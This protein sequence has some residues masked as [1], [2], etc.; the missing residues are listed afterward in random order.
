[1]RLKRLEALT[2]GGVDE[3]RPSVYGSSMIVLIISTVSG[4]I[5]FVA[6]VTLKTA[7]WHFKF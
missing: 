4:P 7:A 5:M 2:P 3:T 1:M 6:I